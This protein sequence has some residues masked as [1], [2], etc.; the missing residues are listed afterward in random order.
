MAGKHVFCEKP[1]ALDAES[2]GRVLAAA[3]KAQGILTVGFN[4]RFAPMLIEAKAALDPRSGPLVML[5]RINAG[6]VPADN[7][8]QRAEGGGRIL[9]EVCHFIDALTFLAGALP[10]EV[11]AIAARNRTGSASILLRFADGSAGTIVY[12]PL[13]D[14]S[15]PK[16]YI[17]VFADGRAVQLE[18]FT[19]CAYR[20]AEK[21][22]KAKQ[23]KIRDSMP[24]YGLFLRRFGAPAQR[25][26]RLPSWLQF[27]RRRSPSRRA[28]AQGRRCKL[29]R[30]G[31]I[32][33]L[34]L[35]SCAGPFI[36]GSW[37]LRL[38]NKGQKS[39]PSIAFS[40]NGLP[41]Y[42]ARQVRYALDSLGEDCAVIGSKPVV[43]V[44]GMEQ[45]LRRPI[46][47]IDAD[48]P[49]SWAELGLDVPQFFFQ[50]GWAYPGFSALGAEVK[51]QGGWVIG[52]SDANWRRDFRQLVLGA[53]AFRLKY[54]RYFDAMLVPGR[55]GQRLMR[56][57]GVPN[58][59]IRCG[60]YGADP[61]IF[62]GGPDLD[63]PAAGF[64]IHRPVYPTQGGDRLGPCLPA[65]RRAP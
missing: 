47:W 58:S 22:G 15:V 14:P 31:K 23:L 27:R 29:V 17:E 36:A 53:L 11:H 55:Q 19:R 49:A 24:W 37:E 51:R 52:V 4:R 56:W 13:G 21:P 65:L 16:E 60:M 2:L 45:A 48:K 40:W 35:R 54:G 41:Q 10:V 42:A 18:D 61:A 39:M 33:M 25:R 7:W 64:F 3:E 30:G 44:K 9:G 38:K 59:R 63:Q 28:C 8:I 62:S 34:R 12:S 20:G 1:L 50:S 32:G 5:Y 26:F 57:F 46:H 43:P 6:Q